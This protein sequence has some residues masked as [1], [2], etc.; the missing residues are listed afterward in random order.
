MAN[1]K[2]SRLAAKLF[3]QYRVPADAGFKWAE[4]LERADSEEDLSPELRDFLERPHFKDH[5]G[6]RMNDVSVTQVY[7]DGKWT[8]TDAVD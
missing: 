5:F 3:N 8:S 6:E 4:E 1:P 2:L 7:I